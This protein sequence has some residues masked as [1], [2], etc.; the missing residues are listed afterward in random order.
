MDVQCP[1]CHKG[2]IV[3]GKIFNQRDYV[4]PKAYFRP[5]DLPFFAFI[6][7]NVWMENRFFA[8]SFC[9]HVWSKIDTE[10]LTQV[11][12]NSGLYRNKKNIA[13]SDGEVYELGDEKK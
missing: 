2:G 13:P 8:C 5:A 11:V 3:E 10:R 7:T 6:G 4:D 1:L 9:G 12:A